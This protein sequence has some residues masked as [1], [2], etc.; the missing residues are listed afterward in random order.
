M[1]RRLASEIRV[2]AIRGRR[3]VDGQAVA[4]FGLTH[5]QECPGCEEPSVGKSSY[6]CARPPPRLVTAR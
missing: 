6:A 2:N 4:N 3:A 1:R 5:C